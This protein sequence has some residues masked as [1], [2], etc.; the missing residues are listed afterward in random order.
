MVWSWVTLKVMY[1]VPEAG[2]VQGTEGKLGQTVTK[3][4]FTYPLFRDAK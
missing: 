3:L 1:S 4:V 2:N